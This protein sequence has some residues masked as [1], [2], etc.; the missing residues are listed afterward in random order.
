[1]DTSN[2]AKNAPSLSSPTSRKK[3]IR[4]VVSI[5]VSQ[6][7]IATI[8]AAASLNGWSRS[9]TIELVF[10]PN[11]S[12]LFPRFEREDPFSKVVIDT[13]LPPDLIREAYAQWRQGYELR[14]AEVPA[15][16]KMKTDVQKLRLEVKKEAV[17]S[18]ERIA[19][20]KLETKL[21]LAKAKIDAEE[22]RAGSKARE[23]R[24]LSLSRP[25]KYEAKP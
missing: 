12:D 16:V 19:K 1:M 2:Y 5:S 7:C 14:R 3:R 15:T 6:I 10:G 21:D 11:L 18:Q 22:I 23:L 17:E 8:D 13:A 4:K 24:A 25:S 20:A 9:R